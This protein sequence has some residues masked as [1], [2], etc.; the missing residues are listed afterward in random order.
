MLSK[1]YLSIDIETTGL[2]PHINEV[3]QIGA[4][5][6]EV[7][8]NGSTNQFD[9]REISKFSSMIKPVFTNNIDPEAMKVNLLSKSDL[10]KSPRSHIVTRD[11]IEWWEETLGGETLHVLGQ[12]FGGFDKA[13]LT[14]FFGRFYDSMFHYHSVDTWTEAELCQ[15]LGLLPKDLKLSLEPLCD[16]FNQIRLSH[17]AL[18][19][20]YSALAIHVELLNLIKGKLK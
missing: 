6:C 8:L 13:F 17:S 5:Y 16:Y 9:I 20:A 1:Y 4:V 2:D 12:N 19:D 3:I 18:S 7:Y 14:K 15:T 11:F 10:E